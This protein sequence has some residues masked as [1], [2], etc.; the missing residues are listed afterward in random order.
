MLESPVPYHHR[1]IRIEMKIPYR[2]FIFDSDMHV[3]DFFDA[4][5]DRTWLT[6]PPW[7]LKEISIT[8]I[9]VYESHDRKR[10]L[11]LRS[12]PK[13]Y[14]YS[15]KCTQSVKSCEIFEAISK[16]FH[17]TTRG[18]IWRAI[19]V[20]MIW[21]FWQ[22]FLTHTAWLQFS[23]VASKCP[24][25]LLGTCKNYYP[26]LSG[27]DV[28]SISF[29]WDIYS[30]IFNLMKGIISSMKLFEIKMCED[31]YFETQIHLIL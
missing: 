11:E 10:C 28:Q 4:T 13:E 5:N 24:I 15:I 30:T 14:T 31:L 20:C 12:A 29:L 6:R 16:H 9:Q 3:F 18:S 7:S 17:C 19:T 21:S 23:F 22:Q 26:T 27:R 8:E 1:N 25:T 2:D